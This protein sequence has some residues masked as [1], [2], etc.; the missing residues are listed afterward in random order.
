MQEY[1]M[2]HITKIDNLTR[3]TRR[4]DF[5][6]GLMDFV[7]AGIFL[8]IG[9]FTGFFTSP[10]GLRWY[11]TSLLQNR[12]ITIIAEITLFAL[13][14]LS[15][16]GARRLIARIRRK[17]FWKNRGFVKPLRWQVSWKINTLAAGVF[18][19][20]L[21]I[22]FWLML[23]GSVSQ[24]SVLRTLVSAAGVA[25]G[26]VLFGM[27]NELELQRYKRVGAAGGVLSALIILIPVSFS[28]SWFALG[29]GWMIVFATSGIWALQRSLVYSREADIE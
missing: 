6:D 10:V 2:D 27:G 13:F 23:N 20:M 18:I 12:E 28:T 7:F 14:I 9:L 21:V 15:V 29:I 8:F 5:E 17:N 3:V 11:L 1:E 24:E 25:T 16:F 4:R 22:A 26:F 19:A